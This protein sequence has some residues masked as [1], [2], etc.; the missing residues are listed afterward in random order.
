MPPWLF[1]ERVVALS[2]D[3][4]FRWPEQL[5]IH[6]GLRKASVVLTIHAQEILAFREKPPGAPSGYGDCTPIQI[7]VISCTTAI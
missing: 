1:F 5:K 4:P 6:E 3:F 7:Y 2:F